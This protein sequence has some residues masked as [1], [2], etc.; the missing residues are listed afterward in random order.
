MGM[1]FICPILATYVRMS[2]IGSQ[3]MCRSLFDYKI[4]LWRADQMKMS[5]IGQIR[6][7]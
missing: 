5:K 3:E 4:S 2:L 7:I 6:T 1:W